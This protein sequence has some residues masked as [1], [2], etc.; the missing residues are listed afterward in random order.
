MA[1]AI[2]TNAGQAHVT[3]RL[4]ADA[5]P[6]SYHIGWGSSATAPAVTQTALGAENAEAR[7]AATTT[8]QT[9]QSTNDTVRHVG[10]I[11]ATGNRVVN[12]AGVFTAAAAGDMTLR[13]THSTLNIETG[14]RVE[15][16]FDLQFTDVSGV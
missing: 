5:A 15:Y 2:F 4:T 10:T 11:T 8:R 14:D 9:T 1:T 7:A 16:T 13:G 3:A 6:T 12:E